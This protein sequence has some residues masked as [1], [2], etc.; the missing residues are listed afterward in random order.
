MD[1]PIIS[2]HFPK[3]G[4]TSLRK[5]LGVHFCSTL[6]LDFDHDPLGP[7]GRE[8]ADVLPEGIRLVH[9]H[10]RASRHAGIHNAFRFTFLRHPITNLMSIYYYWLDQPEHGN[11]VHT[12]F[13]AERPALDAFAT[14]GP[15][16]TLMSEAYFGGFDM[17]RLD[18]VGFH[19]SRAKDVQRLGGLL[20]V[21]LDA[22]LHVNRTEGHWEDRNRATK[23]EKMMGRVEAALKADIDFYE[24]QR[25]LRA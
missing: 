19:E 8:T 4:G 7:H 6:M 16:R 14:F 1:K 10:F 17:K 11:P 13:L 25:R 5:Q 9:G 21:P 22:E 20:G 24:D 15:F 18:F 3:A 2:I 12:A 23:D